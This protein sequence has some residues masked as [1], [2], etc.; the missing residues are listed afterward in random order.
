MTTTPTVEGVLREARDERVASALCAEVGDAAGVRWTA[1]VGRLSWEAEAPAATPDTIFDLA[2]LT[3]V[4]ATASLAARLVS[5]R[6]LDLD[7]P[8]AARVIEWDGD[9]RRDVTARDLLSHSAGLPAYREYFRDRHG[10]AAVVAAACREPLAYPP[11]TTSIYSDLGFFVLGA[12]LEQSAA[13][14]LDAQFIAWRRAAGLTAPLTF[15]PPTDWR[16]ATAMTT[17][18]RWR[19]RRLQ[20]EV[21]DENAVVMDG[22]AAHAGLFGT[23]AAVGEV[24]RWWLQRLRGTDDPESGVTADVV[25]HFARPSAVPGS[26]RAL[27]WDTMRTTSS[28]GTRMSSA[29]IGHTGFTGTSLWLDPGRDRYYVLLT[30]RVLG[31]AD[32]DAMQ[33]VR[34]AFHDRAIQELS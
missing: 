31:A 8:V 27:A 9:D 15:R 19:Q 10:A 11:R 29:A 7:A 14:T 22:V 12:L 4:L 21:H 32:G 17:D 20:G 34:R 18:S 26:S 2:S 25:A 24:A 28:C 30:N 6:A 3:K 23:A 5:S 1:A 33:R 16:A 13:T